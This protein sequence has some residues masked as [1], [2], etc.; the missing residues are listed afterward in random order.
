VAKKEIEQIGDLKGK[1]IGVSKG[2]NLEY[3]LS[4]VLEKNSVA[5]SDVTLIDY[6]GEELAEAFIRGDVDAILTWQPFANEAA[7]QGSGRILFDSSDIPGLAPVV[8][9]FNK[10][11]I[12]SH[13][14]DVQ[15]YVNVWHKTTEFI[16]EHPGEAFGIIARKYNV[17]PGEVQAFAQ[18]DKILDLRDNTIAFAYAPG[19]QSLHG[20][21][22]QINNFMIDK[23]I[24]DQQLD[25]TTFIDARFIRAIT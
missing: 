13:P 21:A 19:F 14:N 15:A 11:Y 17:T 18:Q 1:R 25:S 10:S 22:R 24:T 23:G 4:T 7:A 16:K 6:P 9:V 20:T 8:F 5:G 12:D 3:E 2:T